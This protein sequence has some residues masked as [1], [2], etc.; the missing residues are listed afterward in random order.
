MVNLVNLYDNR[1][2]N[3]YQ[4]KQSMKIRNLLFFLVFTACIQSATAATMAPFEL[5]GSISIQPENSMLSVW[6]NNNIIFNDHSEISTENNKAY[7]FMGAMSSPDIW[8]FDWNVEAD[9]DPFIQANFTVTNTSASSQTFN[10]G[11]NLPIIPVLPDALKFGSLAFTATDDSGDG[12]ASLSNL[13]WDG[14]ID[15]SSALQLFAFAG[16]LNCGGPG[17]SANIGPVSQGFDLHPGGASDTIGIALSFDL[18]AGDSVTFD[19]RFE[20]T[21]VP[22]PAAAW[23]FGSALIVLFSVVRK[24]QI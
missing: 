8:D 18:S 10:I 15:G 1:L 13:S 4:I 6:A 21:A 11:L 20:I 5:S 22:V 23:L 2:I 16:T 24:Q 7:R 9:N 3:S 14:L 17:C 12:I 19:T